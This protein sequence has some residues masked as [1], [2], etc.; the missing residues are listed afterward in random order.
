MVSVKRLF[1][2]HLE[3]F[4]VISVAGKVREIILEVSEFVLSWKWQCSY[5]VLGPRALPIQCQV[6]LG[7]FCIEAKPNLHVCEIVRFFFIRKLGSFLSCSKFSFFLRQKTVSDCAVF[8]M[9]TFF[10]GEVTGRCVRL[11]GSATGRHG[12]NRQ[13]ETADGSIQGCSAS[14]GKTSLGN[15]RLWNHSAMILL[16]SYE[17]FIEDAYLQDVTCA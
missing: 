10:Y 12:C 7:K 9:Q 15:K 14:S 17:P 13:G 3:Y 2:S 8:D 6:F 16:D 11:F 1:V 5:V 4:D